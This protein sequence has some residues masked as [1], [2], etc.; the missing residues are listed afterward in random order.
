ME[1][2]AHV[3]PYTGL[4]L[5]M[6]LLLILGGCKKQNWLQ[7]NI[8]IFFSICAVVAGPIMWVLLPMAAEFLVVSPP[9]FAVTHKYA[10][11]GGILLSV[12]GMWLWWRYIVPVFGN[13]AQ[14]LTRR[15]PLERNRRT[16]VR[17]IADLLPVPRKADFDPRR[18]FRTKD[19]FIACDEHG[20]PV[21][22]SWAAWTSTHVDIIGT[23]GAGKGAAAGVLLSQSIS[24]GEAV[25]I[26]DPKNDE[27]LPH[28][29]R[30]AAGE[31][32]VPFHLI[33]LNPQFGPQ[34]NPLAGAEPHE[35]EEMLIAGFGLTDKGEGA[36]HYRRKDRKLTR[37]LFGR[38]SLASEQT[39]ASLYKLL[40]QDD[41]SDD[42]E[43]FFDQL[44]EL[45]ELRS[46]NAFHGVDLKKIIR[47]GGCVYFIGSMRN[48][49]VIAAQRIL[50]IRL[51]QLAEKRDRSVAL[52]SIAIFL[53]EL[54]HH[55][56]RPALEALAAARDKG[57]HLVLAHQSIADLRDCPRD[58]NPDSVVGAIVENT[59]I[60]IAYRLQDPDTAEWVA[61]MSG[62]ILVDE[63]F[64]KVARNAGLAE[65]MEGERQLRASERY[66]IDTNMLLNMPYRC[67]AIFGIG[68]PSFGFI[69]PVP[70]K[71]KVLSPVIQQ[72]SSAEGQG[73]SG[74]LESVI[75]VD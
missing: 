47:D 34:L 49:R 38:D 7:K 69:S 53:D 24:H 74:I 20:R 50:L 31:A 13:T 54:K 57:V 72:V 42:S 23:T 51:I 11:V 48:A 1:F 52:R 33:N 9:W 44:A 73:H 22:I 25:F 60:K 19:M 65:T 58:L 71:K 39:F 62:T 35:I 14:R 45:A 16:D 67:A 10:L 64:R 32:G 40:I 55:I 29:L 17:H 66:L 37:A 2:E 68:L 6:G 59:K 30:D 36:D 26:F 18:Y 15:S 43:G 46:V 70:T 21:R 12:V 63:E 4:V 8:G 27:F 75:D 5:G 3:W 41:V 61:R 28:V 56:S